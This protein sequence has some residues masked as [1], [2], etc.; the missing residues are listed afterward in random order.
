MF[1]FDPPLPGAVRVAEVDGHLGG[2]GDLAVLG[3]LGALI[4]GQRLAQVHRQGLDRGQEAVA[5]GEGAVAGGQV[6]RWISIANRVWR[7]TKVAMA[8]RQFAPST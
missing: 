2:H 6:G 5:D 1:S 4:P 3:Q 7:S 8:E